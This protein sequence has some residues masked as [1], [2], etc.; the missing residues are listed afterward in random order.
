M[1]TGHHL[2]MI[3]PIDIW[4]LLVI[5]S[6]KHILKCHKTDDTCNFVKVTYD[7]E[8]RKN[9][10]ISIKMIIVMMIIIAACTRVMIIIEYIYICVYIYNIHAHIIIIYGN[11]IILMLLNACVL[12]LFIYFLIKKKEKTCLNAFAMARFHQYSIL[13]RCAVC[14][15]Y[16]TKFSF[17]T[18]IIANI[19]FIIKWNRSN[20]ILI[21][22]VPGTFA[23]R[24]ISINTN[25]RFFDNSFKH[26]FELIYSRLLIHNHSVRIYQ[27][28]KHVLKTKSE[29]WK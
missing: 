17:Y 21:Q 2:A 7:D 4:P 18:L 1:T 20:N 13:C 5:H 3:V 16:V 19:N 29:T 28:Y 26:N 23:I 27:Q 24:N 14:V 10:G 25:F 9:M 22:G 8:K 11:F 12:L 6:I 15:L